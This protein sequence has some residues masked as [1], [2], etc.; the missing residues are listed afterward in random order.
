MVDME[1]LLHSNNSQLNM[2]SR[3]LPKTNSKCNSSK[4]HAWDSTKIC[5]LASS[6]TVVTSQFARTT[7]TC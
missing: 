3:L 1:N 7:W 6:R 4:T 5:S 2:P